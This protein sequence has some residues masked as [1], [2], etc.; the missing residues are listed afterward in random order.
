MK[1]HWKRR[2]LLIAGATGAACSLLADRFAP[3]A[4]GAEGPNLCLRNGK[5]TTMD[6]ARPEAEAVA[7]VPAVTNAT[8]AAT[9]KRIRKLPVKPEQLRSA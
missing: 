1:A 3:H 7:I 6:K 5:F 8:F 4:H 9:G 2:D